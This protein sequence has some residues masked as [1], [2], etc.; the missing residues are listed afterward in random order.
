[1]KIL[2]I[3]NKIAQQQKALKE[4]NKIPSSVDKSEVVKSKLNDVV[5]EVIS[6]RDVEE[7]WNIATNDIGSF[8]QPIIDFL[9]LILTKSMEEV[10]EQYDTD[11]LKR[12][13]YNTFN[14]NLQLRKIAEGLMDCNVGYKR[15]YRTVKGKTVENKSKTQKFNADLYDELMRHLT[16]DQAHLVGELC[17]FFE[18][19]EEQCLKLENYVGDLVIYNDLYSEVFANTGLSKELI[20]TISLMKGKTQP[21]RGAFEF[22][23]TIVFKNGKFTPSKDKAKDENDN[24]SKGDIEIDGNNIEVKADTGNGGGRIGGGQGFSNVEYV[25]GEYQKT[26]QSLLKTIKN[27]YFKQS[28]SGTPESQQTFQM[29][30]DKYPDNIILKL[31]QSSSEKGSDAPSLDNVLMDIVGVLAQSGVDLNSPDANVDK[32]KK[33]KS[34]R[35]L[36]VDAYRSVWASL[37]PDKVAV[38]KFNKVIDMYINGRNLNTMLEQMS[39]VDPAE[40]NNFIQS[41]CFIEL[42]YYASKENFQYIFI[43]KTRANSNKMVI[44]KNEYIHTLAAGILSNKTTINEILKNGIKFS[45]PSTLPSAERGIRPAISLA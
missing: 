21:A 4:S 18:N 45:P 17:N 42:D 2:E 38:D 34:L 28:Q 12:I 44:I 22:I 39:I 43:I 7:Q 19:Y 26:I 25:I 11:A 35:G 9:S 3:L 14:S 41:M 13:F 16:S 8:V 29:L 27:I 30:L 5:A 20:D 10:N 23:S 31:V 36:I 24:E 40:Y 1:M 33:N 15:A 37:I 32:S 6:K